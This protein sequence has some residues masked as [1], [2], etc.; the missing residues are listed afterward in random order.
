MKAIIIILLA[1]SVIGVWAF[2]IIISF[3]TWNFWYIFLYFVWWI[4]AS[5]YAK[6][7]QLGFEIVD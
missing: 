7:I 5:I 6:I 3:C 1:L 2:P 4:P